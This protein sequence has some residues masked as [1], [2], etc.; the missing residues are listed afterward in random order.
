MCCRYSSPATRHGDSAGHPRP[1]VNDT[2]KVRSISLQSISA[3]S[4]TS[5]CCMLI[6]SSRCGWNSSAVCGREGFGAIEILGGICKKA[7]ADKT[8][9]C[10]SCA[11][12]AEKLPAESTGCELFRVDYVK[13]VGQG[14]VYS[15]QNTNPASIARGIEGENNQASAVIV[16]TTISDADMASV[17]ARTWGKP[18]AQNIQTI[19]STALTA[20]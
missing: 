19:F 11:C 6:C 3:A 7:G 13:G 8:I 16:Q 2:A 17:A 12:Q 15:P 10:K 1:E 5:G 9:P 20:S 14:D 4:L 18:T